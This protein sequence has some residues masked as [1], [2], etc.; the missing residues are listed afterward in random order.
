[1][2]KSLI[3][4]AGGLLMSVISGGLVLAQSRSG[5]SDRACLE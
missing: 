2:H 3:L 4:V 5:S 1:M